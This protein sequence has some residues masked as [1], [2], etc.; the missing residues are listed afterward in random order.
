MAHVA[1][2]K[3]AWY[4]VLEERDESGRRRQ[5]W[6]PGFRSEEQARAVL[7]IYA[8]I[9]GEAR[10][11]ASLAGYLRKWHELR[12]R[13]LRPTT[14]EQYRWVMERYVVPH[15]GQLPLAAVR[16]QDLD[17]LYDRLLEAELAPATVRLV[18]AI[19]RKAFADAVRRGLLDNNPALAATP[20]RVEQEETTVLTPKQVQRL[21][22]VARQDEWYALWRLAVMTGMRRGELL[23]LRREDIDFE[24]GVLF[25]RRTVVWAGK[26]VVVSPPKTRRSLRALLLDPETLA[27]LEE[28]AS[29]HAACTWLWS[30]TEEPPSPRLLNARFER[31]L[32]RAG[33]PHIRFHDLRHTN[34]TLGL[35]AGV[36]PKVMQARLG[37]HSAAFTMDRYQHVMLGMQAPA[38][39]AISR[40]LAE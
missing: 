4:I 9:E 22:D 5:R 29:R 33:L 30:C 2:K 40:V 11:A 38:L 19:L 34:A 12:R 31:L 32:Q 37:H 16:G 28:H 25:V 18:H 35:L 20:P 8:R 6:V 15:I 3:N 36:D 13:A 24:A 17:D 14:W 1:R 21:L 26:G 23:G 27:A 7:P 10:E 39:E